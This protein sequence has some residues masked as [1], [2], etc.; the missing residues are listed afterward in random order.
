M[1]SEF[2]RRVE[3]LAGRSAQGQA[4]SSGANQPP[5][6]VPSTPPILDALPALLPMPAPIPL[7]PLPP[8]DLSAPP[9]SLDPSMS[10]FDTIQT[11]VV[12][13]LRHTLSSSESAQL[14]DALDENL[15][16]LAPLSSSDRA[17]LLSAPLLQT[18][19]DG[20]AAQLYACVLSAMRSGPVGQPLSAFVEELDA[21]VSAIVGAA[22]ADIFNATSA[23]YGLSLL[24]TARIPP[25]GMQAAG[26]QI[27]DQT[28]TVVQASQI[29]GQGLFAAS[30]IPAGTVVAAMRRS[31]RMTRGEWTT[32]FVASGLPHDAAV[33]VARSP[34]VFYD[35]AWTDPSSP[36]KWYRLNHSSTPN[37]VPAI[38]D[39][40]RPPR[41]QVLVWR[42]VR[43]VAQGEELVFKY[44]DTP[45][46]WG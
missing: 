22:V 18:L 46:E 36:P 30:T 27:V 42:T 12:F 37:A 17:R 19:L 13:H 25:T 5:A 11:L 15:S 10:F 29:A 3:E 39:R 35:A 38:L 2:A 23:A 16:A 9:S 4:S 20:N 24:S 43:P 34:L 6:P 45:E 14:R 26:H 7:P 40:S 41:E 33:Y 1:L 21:N 31:A 28:L 32:H 44:V 8:L